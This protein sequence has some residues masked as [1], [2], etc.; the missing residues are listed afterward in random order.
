MGILDAFTSLGLSLP[1]LIA[2]LINFGV[3]FGILFLVAYKPLMKM[4][5]ERSNKIKESMEQ[6]EYVKQQAIHAE[7][8]VKKQ[9]ESASKRGQEV[10]SRAEKSGE[11]LRQRMQEQAKREGESLITGA[12]SEIQ[13]ERDDA[14]SEMRKEFADLTI[15]A[16]G[17]VIDESLDKDKHRDIIDKVLEESSVLKKN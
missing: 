14:I 3:L 7:E 13:R 2:Q 1:N 15:M 8:E 11:E 9:L 4:L 12:R 16:A 10:I 6:A 5:D 17:K